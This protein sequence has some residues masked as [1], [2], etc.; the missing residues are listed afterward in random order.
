[1]KFTKSLIAATALT[2]ASTAA[3][4]APKTTMSLWG[5]AYLQQSTFENDAVAAF[6]GDQ[7][8]ARGYVVSGLY[9][10]FETQWSGFTT[11]AEVGAEGDNVNLSALWA[12]S[13]YMGDKLN[14]KI[15]LQNDGSGGLT[16]VGELDKSIL[17][18][19]TPG[20][21]FAY[22]LG[23]GVV[24]LFSGS[25]P[26]EW[27]YAVVNPTDGTLE[28][29]AT[30][31]FSGGS[32]Y[33]GFKYAGEYGAT[34][35]LLSHYMR[36]TGE[37]KAGGA[38][39]VEDATQSRTTVGVTHAIGSTSAGL[40]YVMGTNGATAD[41]GDDTEVAIIRAKLAHAF[42]MWVPSFSY[43]SN[44]SKVGDAETA[45]TEMELDVAYNLGEGQQWF[46]AYN[47]VGTEVGDA[48]A[49]TNTRI[50]I[51]ARFDAAADL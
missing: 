2:A 3:A 35:V 49:V 1:M 28:S 29:D 45:V 33:L 9:L 11:F 24:S 20:V 15:G 47:S 44:V 48:D 19:W 25:T 7:T 30:S 26:D 36:S 42:G 39:I 40:D 50:F 16:Q 12:S 46:F 6:D 51:G 18:N 21:T 8:V 5:E 31:G 41:G 17:G 38:V 27:Y 14:V 23:A 37:Y 34:N 43:H 32:P 13:N 22:D 4:E 10:G